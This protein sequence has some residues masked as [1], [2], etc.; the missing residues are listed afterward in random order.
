MSSQSPS[1]SA[2]A[3][4]LPDDHSSLPDH[5]SNFSDDHD[6]HVSE[7][8]ASSHGPLQDA[9]S[10]GQSERSDLLLPGDGAGD[11]EPHTEN[12]DSDFDNRSDFTDSST[13]RDLS[14]YG[15]ARG[16]VGGDGGDRARWVELPGIAGGGFGAC[17]RLENSIN[18]MLLRSGSWE[19]QVRLS[20]RRLGERE[21]L[22]R[23]AAAK[24]RSS[25][26]LR[27]EVEESWLQEWAE[28]GAGGGRRGRGG[29]LS[30]FLNVE[31]VLLVVFRG[32]EKNIIPY[33]Q[34]LFLVDFSG[35]GFCRFVYLVAEC[36]IPLGRHPMSPRVPRQ[37]VSGMQKF[38]NGSRSSAAAQRPGRTSCERPEECRS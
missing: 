15:E 9:D 19:K 6:G 31:V 10:G 17:R 8:G 4:S 13:L 36:R 28:E 37:L 30:C 5:V 20:S 3:H 38:G 7:A 22:A 29:C 11:F 34:L 26:A 35:T 23:E 27:A 21:F 18:E 24:I 12:V 1:N 32:G 33:P 14:V 25:R 16:G 2:G